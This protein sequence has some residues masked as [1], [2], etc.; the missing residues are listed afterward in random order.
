MLTFRTQWSSTSRCFCICLVGILPYCSVRPTST[1][2]LISS[3]R[4]DVQTHLKVRPRDEKLARV[5]P[6]HEIEH[7]ARHA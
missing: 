2:C 3:R 6:I 7:Q 5:R 1:V 4:C